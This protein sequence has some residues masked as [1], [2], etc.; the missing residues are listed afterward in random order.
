MILR[1]GWGVEVLDG[2]SVAPESLVG[3][4]REEGAPSEF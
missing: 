2:D 4:A 1:R 3:G